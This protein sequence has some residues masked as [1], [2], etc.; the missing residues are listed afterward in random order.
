MRSGILRVI[1]TV[2]KNFS[3]NGQNVQISSFSEKLPRVNGW[4]FTSTKDIK[5]LF[6]PSNQKFYLL[7]EDTVFLNFYDSIFVTKLLLYRINL[8][9]CGNYMTKCRAWG[10]RSP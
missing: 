4:D 5:L 3:R 1:S 10:D 8:L 9:I 7:S 6:L 2:P